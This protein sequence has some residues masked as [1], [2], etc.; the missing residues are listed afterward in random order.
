M[1]L[2]AIKK[3]KIAG[4]ITVDELREKA[5]DLTDSIV[6]AVT[7]NET[8]MGETTI[9]H[10]ADSTNSELAKAL[11]LQGANAA[12]PLGGLYGASKVLKD[13]KNNDRLINLL[14]HRLKK[15]GVPVLR[16]N[17]NPFYTT[18]SIVPILGKPDKNTARLIKVP[19]FP[20]GMINAKKDGLLANYGALAHEGGHAMVRKV[21]GPGSTYAAIGGKQV[22]GLLALA[23]ALSAFSS[24]KKSK[25][26]ENLAIASGLALTPTI[27]NEVHASI[28]GSQLLK[29]LGVKGLGRASPF[30]GVGTYVASATSPY[31]G[32]KATRAIMEKIRNRKKSQRDKKQGK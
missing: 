14:R 25:T 24:N 29:G 15:E 1:L 18:H 31:L 16:S 21:N 19:D 2:T 20:H 3:K 6:D 12:L 13:T 23:A 26:A 28:K 9:K 8:Q 30:I 11:T 32:V 27:A 10:A 17:S 4:L 22:S 7:P 5:D